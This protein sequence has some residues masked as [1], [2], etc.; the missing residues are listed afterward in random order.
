MQLQHLVK[1][2]KAHRLAKWRATQWLPSPKSMPS[3][4]TKPTTSPYKQPRIY[5][6]SCC[7]PHATQESLV[8]WRKLINWKTVKFLCLSY[9]RARQASRI[10]K[11]GK[12]EWPSRNILESIADIKWKP[13]LISSPLSRQ[14][15]G[16]WQRAMSR[17]S[18]WPLYMN[19]NTENSGAPH[20]WESSG[21]YTAISTGKRLIHKQCPVHL[22]SE[23]EGYLYACPYW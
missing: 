4:L 2:L 12:H 9:Y 15:H 20:A 5:T 16:T 21:E 23:L 22:L 14:P 6:C 17:S 19:A 1:F 18:L 13:S 10:S 11:N 3:Y 8:A 7:L